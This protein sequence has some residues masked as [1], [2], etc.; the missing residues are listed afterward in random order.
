MAQ[1]GLFPS[2]VQ[3]YYHSNFGPH[4]MTLPTR[5]WSPGLDQGTFS[6]W[7]ATDHA[8]DDMIT[9]L[10]TAFA[11]LF[12]TNSEFDYYAIWNYP[13]EDALPEQVAFGELGIAGTV[14]PGTIN[15]KAV[16]TT[17]SWACDGGFLLKTCL[18]DSNA[19]AQFGKVNALGILTL[20]PDIVTEVTGA[21]NGWASRAGTQPLFGK[22]IAY[23][24]NEKL[25]RN[26]H[27][28]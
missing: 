27:E 10:V 12:T 23:T 9:A 7:S 21:A 14:T 19:P 26:Y 1:Y 5:Q 8:A 16:Q 11:D 2:F 22:Q 3:V 13:D 17:I 15:T 20:I 18:M 25:R 4:V 6:T 24:L 28:N